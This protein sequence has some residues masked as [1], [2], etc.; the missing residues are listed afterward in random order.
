MYNALH[1]QIQFLLSNILVQIYCYTVYSHMCEKANNNGIKSL[2]R[3]KKKIVLLLYRR[4]AI[5]P[6]GRKYNNY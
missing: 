6:I 5:G 1:V 4:I 2:N 3:K